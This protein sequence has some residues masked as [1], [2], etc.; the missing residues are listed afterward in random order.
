MF[1]N[2]KNIINNYFTHL[3]NEGIGLL[4]FLN[5][6]MCGIDDESGRLI[7]DIHEYF[8]RWQNLCGAG[9]G[10]LISLLSYAYSLTFF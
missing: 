4:I 3:S 9:R 1:K 5:S 7:I 6:N 10:L 8:G 2:F